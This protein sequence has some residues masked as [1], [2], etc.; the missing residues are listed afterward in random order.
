[1]KKN[2][3]IFLCTVIVYC[4]TMVSCQSPE[5]NQLSKDDLT[6]IENAIESYAQACEANDWSMWSNIFAEDATL[7]PPGG[8]SV[9]GRTAIQGWAESRGATYSDMTLSPLETSGKCGLAVSRGSYSSTFQSE[10]APA[11]STHNGKW[12]FVWKKQS[13]GSW[14]L[15]WGTWNSKAPPRAARMSESN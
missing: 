14:K 8:P 3:I 2:M 6:A 4:I 1:M 5:S 10:S 11:A 15:W 13:D 12:I 7:M 9:Q